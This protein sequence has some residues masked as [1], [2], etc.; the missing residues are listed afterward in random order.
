MWFKSMCGL[1]SKSLREKVCECFEFCNA[2]VDFFF[3]FHSLETSS[4]HVQ[5]ANF[6]PLLIVNIFSTL[7]VTKG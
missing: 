5:N 2:L 6:F 7:D 4:E 1:L 3:S